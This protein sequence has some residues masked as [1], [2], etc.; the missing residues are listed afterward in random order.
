MKALILLFM[1]MLAGP[2]LAKPDLSQ[3]MG[4]TLA[5]SGSESYSFERFDLAAADNQRHYRVY[6]A[7]PKQPAPAAGYPVM[8][9]LD[10]N[11]ALASLQESWLAEAENP[12]LLVMIGYDTELR[13]EPLARTFDYTPSPLTGEPFADESSQGRMAGGA[14]Q[15]LELI[16]TR[17]KPQVNARHRVDRQQQTLWGHSYG[18]VFVLNCLFVRPDAFQRYVAVSPSLWWQ[19]GLLLQVEKQLPLKARA[20]VMILQG[21]QEGRAGKGREMPAARAQAMRA[22]GTDALAKMVARLAAYPHIEVDY[23]T[24][25]G[26][27]HG[28]M[29]AASIPLAMQFA[30]EQ[31]AP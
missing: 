1:A 23:Q 11:A 26:L 16:E 2:V 31:G 20:R 4:N 3:T 28:P 29:F 9:M 12:P 15:F 30:T 19:S 10:G 21:E 5:R 25:K 18:G 7:V 14:S 6:L 24:L 17:I 22:V 13:I 27:G 8:Y